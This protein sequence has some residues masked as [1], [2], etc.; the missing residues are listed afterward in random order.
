MSKRRKR[1]YNHELLILNVP[2]TA[3]DEEWLNCL[4]TTSDTAAEA[5]GNTFVRETL[6]LLSRKQRIVVF[7]TVIE[8]V[9][10]R[11]VANELGLSQQAIHRLKIRALRRL[12]V[13]LQSS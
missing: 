1:L 4:A 13:Y 11:V 7:E 6:S 2:T 12:Q 8:D 3:D 10:E 5:I 9:P